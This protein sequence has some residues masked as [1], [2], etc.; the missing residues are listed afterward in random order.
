MSVEAADLDGPS[1]RAPAGLRAEEAAVLALLRRR[2][3]RG[4][5]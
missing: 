1:G 2:V 4:A 3:R 5:A